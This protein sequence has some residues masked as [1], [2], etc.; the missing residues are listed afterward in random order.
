[1]LGQ[2][3]RCDTSIPEIQIPGSKNKQCKVSQYADDTTL[4]LANNF[5]TT[6]AF[7]LINIF[8]RGS[9]SQLNPKKTEGLWIGS[10]PGRTSGPVKITWV[11]DKLKIL[12]VG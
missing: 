11:T 4:I 12:S 9:G 5:S 2:A 6:R 8:E 3:I 10:Y 7:N 1:M